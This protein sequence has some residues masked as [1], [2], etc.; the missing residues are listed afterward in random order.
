MRM[1]GRGCWPETSTRKMEDL[2]NLRAVFTGGKSGK[3]RRSR[4]GE[5][6][7]YHPSQSDAGNMLP[8]IYVVIS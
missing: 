3:R 2:L 4:D 6:T 1:R 7:V 8:Y 5:R